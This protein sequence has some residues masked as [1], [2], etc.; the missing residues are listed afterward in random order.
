MSL[1]GIFWI[2]FCQSGRLGQLVFM[3]G[4]VHRLCHVYAELL[5]TSNQNMWFDCQLM[6]GD[7]VERL[8]GI[9]TSLWSGVWAVRLSLRTR[10]GGD[11]WPDCPGLVNPYI[12]SMEDDGKR[13]DVQSHTRPVST[14]ADLQNFFIGG[15]H[16]QLFITFSSWFLNNSKAEY[17]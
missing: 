4:W 6:P 13:R 2:H 9:W 11:E 12:V 16:C 1:A 5:V 7:R 10:S 3:K 14:Q 8:A 17:C 15:N